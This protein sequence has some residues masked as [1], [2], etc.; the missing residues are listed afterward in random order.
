M[1][2]ISAP[3]NFLRGFQPAIT[4]QLIRAHVSQR[5]FQGIKQ[6][7]EAFRTGPFFP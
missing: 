6:G 7:P 2:L 3:Q 1:S 4:T 5:L